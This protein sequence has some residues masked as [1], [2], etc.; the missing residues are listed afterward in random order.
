[1]FA[2]K[3][4]KGESA[5]ESKRSIIDVRVHHQF[6]NQPAC[7]FDIAVCK[8]GEDLGASQY[9]SKHFSNA[10]LVF[11]HFRGYVSPAQ[12][13]EGMI[14]EVAGYPA[15]KEGRFLAHSGPIK[16]LKE[17]P[18]GGCVIS[19]EVDTTAG[20]SGSGISLLDNNLVQNHPNLA[21]MR[22]S[23]DDCNSNHQIK[24]II[25]GIHTGTHPNGK[26]NY[27]TLITP[28]IDNWIIEKCDEMQ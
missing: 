19:Y 3:R 17:K 4:R 15:E 1:M 22:R 25:I 10:P 9:T 8:L 2:Y 27:G 5:Y 12:L 14:V 6:D 24:K 7:G 20:M 16:E 23:Y 26:V 21:E 18:G 28:A 11:D 13:T